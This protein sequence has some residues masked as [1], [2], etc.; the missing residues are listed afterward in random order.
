MAKYTLISEKIKGV[1]SATYTNGKL[2]LLELELQHPL[3][4]LQADYLFRNM[5]YTECDITER[6]KSQT[7]TKTNEKI[8]LFCAKYSK[9]MSGTKYKVSGAD[10]GKIV[11]VEVTDMLLEIYFTSK[12]F[13]FQGK[14]SIS[15]YVRY[16]NE[17]RAEANGA[18]QYPNYWSREIADKIMGE[19]GGKYAAYLKHLRGLGF[20]AKM[21]GS[22]LIEMTPP[23]G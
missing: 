20:T 14:H 22:I 23:H 21:R 3:T 18:Y 10:S 13:L 11:K 7:T 15:N 16:Y 5:P 19:G 12:N 17:L 1:I 9:Y 4:E 6:W 2:T 8:A